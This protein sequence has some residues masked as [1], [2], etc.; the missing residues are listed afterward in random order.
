MRLFR[1]SDNQWVNLEQVTD[2]I[3]NNPSTVT[4]RFTAMD[5]EGIALSTSAIGKYADKAIQW[6]DQQARSQAEMRAPDR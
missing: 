6:L 2:I 4:F 5:G 1:V 3:I